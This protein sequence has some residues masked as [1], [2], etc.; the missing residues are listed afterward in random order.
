MLFNII[1]LLAVCAVLANAGLVRFKLNKKPNSEF[2]GH[3]RE[4]AASGIKAVSAS[5]GATGNIVITNYANSQYYGPITLGTP[6]QTFNVIFDT[7]S[8]D[9]W[10]ASSNCDSSCGRHAKYNSAKSS[11]YVKNGTAFD[12][13]YGSGPVSG[14]ESQD[15]FSTGGIVINNQV[16]AEVTD[17]SG[18]GA[19]YKLGKFDGILGLAWPVLSVNKVPTVFENMIN[20]KLVD[21]QI[22]SFYLGMTSLTTPDPNSELVMGGSDPAHYS[23]DITYV[24]L[25]ATTYWEITLDQMNSGGKAYLSSP[26]NAIVDSG[27]S[28]LTGPSQAVKDIATAMGAEEIVA[29]EYMVAC[30]KAGLPNLDFVIAGKTYSLAPADYLIPDGEMCLVGLMGMDIPPP[31]G[32]LWILGDVFMRKYYTIF[33]TANKRVG[34][35]LSK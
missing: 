19:A 17:A 10:V 16:F 7:G 9:L 24:P 25:K 28:I 18:L 11:T 5:V 2:V 13:M 29:G 23:G 31:T 26:N 33:D 3:V 30:N 35:A 27:T 22:F 14:Y 34:F 1:V 20:Q 4:L 6:A 15:T 21:Q 8:S 12:I 32:P